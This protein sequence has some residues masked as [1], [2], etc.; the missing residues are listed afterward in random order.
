MAR[1]FPSLTPIVLPWVEESERTSERKKPLALKKVVGDGKP[2][3][4]S[5]DIR[6]VVRGGMEAFS[7][8]RRCRFL[9]FYHGNRMEEKSPREWMRGL[10]ADG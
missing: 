6:I 2:R 9:E 5:V 10:S 1:S 4:L 8:R 3:S 7:I